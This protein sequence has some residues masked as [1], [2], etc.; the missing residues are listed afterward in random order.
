M[1]YASLEDLVERAGMD[2]IVQVADRD[3]DLIPDPEVIG[4]ALVH[5][6][7]IVDGYLAGRYQLPFPQVPDLVRTWATAI[8]R[9]Q[10]HRWDPP[11]YVVA[12]YKDALAQAIREYDDRLP[13][14][15]RALQSDPRQL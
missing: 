7:N 13:Q 2:E 15:L 10:L 11:D 3:G 4:A 6:D 1:T 14:R 8:A 12:D 5:A 9:Y